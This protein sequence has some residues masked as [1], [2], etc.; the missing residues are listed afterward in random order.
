MNQ[1]QDLMDYTFVSKYAGYKKDE[2]RRET[3]KEASLRSKQMHLQKYAGC[4]IEQEL[5][6]AYEA[7]DDLLCVGSQRNLQFAGPAVLKHNARSYNCAGVYCNRARV[8]QEAMYLLLCGTGVGMSVQKHH[9]AHLPNFRSTPKTKDQ[10]YIIDDSIEGWAESIG[11]IINTYFDTHPDF[12]GYKIH[13]DYSKIRPKGSA[14]SHGCGTAPGP[15]PLERAHKK[16]VGHLDR[17]IANGQTALRP[18]DAYDILMYIADAVLSGGIRRSATIIIF[19][20]DDEEMMMAKTGT[21]YKDNP[22][23]ARSN[24]SAA[25][26]RGKV[27]FEEFS[28]LFEFA[29]QFGEPGFFWVDSLEVLCNPCLEILFYCYDTTVKGWKE[30][31]EYSGWQMCN[32]T[33]INGSKIKTKKDFERAVIAAT[34]IGT[35]QAGYDQFPYLCKTSENIIH[36]EAL[37]GVSITGMMENPDILLNPDIQKEMAQIAK[38][39]NKE[40]AAKIKI[41]QAARIT[42]IKPEGSTS[43][44]LG[45]TSGIHPQHSKRFIRR[46]QSNAMEKPTQYYK[47]INPMAVEKSVWSENNSDEVVAFACIAGDKVL[48]KKDVGAIEFLDIVKSTQ[49]NWVTEG[50]NVEYCTQPFLNHNVSNTTIVKNDEWEDVKKY[51]YKN[52]SYFTGISLLADSGDKD[53]NQAPFTAV[54]TPEEIVQEYGSGALFTSGLIEE[55]FR[56]WGDLWKACDAALGMEDFNI[57]NI[58]SYNEA[59]VNERKYWV[60]RLNKFAKNYIKNGDVKRATY[61]LKDIYNNKLFMDL[62]KKHK[63]VDYLKMV[64]EENTTMGTKEVSCQGGACA[65]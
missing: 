8:F 64:E 51:I 26:L 13:F 29:K 55:A 10:I 21:W 18:I 23:R 15:D 41:N 36:R 24:N 45:T 39:V 25:L 30:S 42:C 48:F 16:I 46:V 7:V 5:E 40:I 57:K 60:E 14:F 56:I 50:R 19:S 58:N 11:Y 2:K 63:K 54:F 62:Q 9:V 47:N 59:R 31:P 6:F 43:S 27:T 38:K 3:Y 65:I 37:L 35:C 20:H 49:M 32:L 12:D 53:Y 28:K 4:G 33:S 61:L 52:Q 34:T 44:M 17:C 1:I 22:Q